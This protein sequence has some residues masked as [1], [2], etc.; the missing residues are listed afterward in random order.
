VSDASWAASWR[1]FVGVQFLADGVVFVW[2]THGGLR[3]LRRM[4]ARLRTLERDARDAGVVRA[5]ERS[6]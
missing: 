4:F 5:G 2:F 3:D 1:W 6:G